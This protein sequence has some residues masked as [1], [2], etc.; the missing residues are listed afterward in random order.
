MTQNPEINISTPKL[1]IVTFFL[2]VALLRLTPFDFY[3]SIL[4]GY[5]VEINAL[6]GSAFNFVNY[7]STAGLISL[8]I[9]KSTSLFTNWKDI[10]PFIVLIL[11]YVLNAVQGPFIDLSWVLYQII[12]ILTA[13]FIHI[14]MR[15]VAYLDDQVYLRR[16][17]WIYWGGIMLCLFC[18]VQ[19]LLQN[20][21]TYYFTE[22]NDAFVHSL[23]DFGIMK[24]R[25]GYL[26]GFLLAY[27]LFMIKNPYSRIL[28][29]LLLVFAGFGI[30][31]LI[32]GSVGASILFSTKRP[33]RFFF[34]LLLTFIA[35]YILKDN[36][37]NNIIYDTRF[38]SYANA[39]NIIQNFPFGV[40]LGGYPIYTEEFSRQLF[41]D[42]Y[43]VNSLLDYIPEAPESDYVH[44]FGSLGLTL[45]IVHLFIQLRLLWYTYKLHHIAHSFEKV[46]LFFFCFMTFF[47]ISEDSMFTIYYW[48]F[49]GLASGVISSLIYR[50]R[51]AIDE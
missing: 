25:Y 30:R 13:L 8:F 42:F 23:D 11:V 1:S 22:F 5:P 46:I 24:Q 49:F 47:G 15:K 17:R 16:T 33:S 19:V 2:F 32:L 48:V 4:M 44:L 21:L 50:T 10:W 26:L 43:N 3:F 12:F 51:T 14:Y 29:I 40:G 7:I 31:S 6:G 45:G 28:L 20:N 41:A 34:I 38:Y 37:F 39:W 27:S 35:I 36:Y 9:A 18:T